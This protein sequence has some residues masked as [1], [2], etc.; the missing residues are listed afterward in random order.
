MTATPQRAEAF[1]SQ[2]GEDRFLVEHD[3]V[4]PAGVFVDVGAG[5]PIRYSNTYYFEHIG[6]RGLCIDADPQQVEALARTRACT[7]E[8][9]AVT[10]RTGEVELIQYDDPDFSTTLDDLPDLAAERG[11][12]TAV[13]RVPAQTLETVLERHGIEK[14][15]L[16]SIDTEGSELDVCETLDWDKHRP[17]IVIIEYLTWGRPSQEAAIR[18]YFAKSPYRAIHRTASNL[19]FVESR[20]RRLM[21]SHRR[22]R[23][24]P[25]AAGRDPAPRRLTSRLRARH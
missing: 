8:W 12:H 15:D 3:Q 9:A 20:I 24:S 14:I 17:R 11:W 23:A 2:W 25:H 13:T 19:I 5:D 4:P 6:W 22:M 10:S 16:L 7:V 1:A 18:G 21:W